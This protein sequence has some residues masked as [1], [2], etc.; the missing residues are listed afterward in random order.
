MI[1]IKSTGDIH[2][3]L[4]HQTESFG[5]QPT[6]QEGNEAITILRDWLEENASELISRKNIAEFNGTMMQWFHWYS[7]GDGNHW[8]S[9]VKQAPQLARSGISAVWL[10]PA[11]KGMGGNQE[12]GYAAYDLYD[13]GEFN[14]QGSIRTKYGTKED[15]VQAI[16]ACKNFGIN[17]YADV[18]FNHKIGG[19][20]EEDFDA[21][22][23]DIANRHHALGPARTIRSWTSFTFPGRQGKYSSMQW[24]WWHFDS[25]DY[26]ALEPGLHAVWQVKDKPLENNVNLE[27][28]NYD[29]LMGC[30]LDVAHPE[31]IQELKS[32]GEWNLDHLGVNGFRL[33]AIK[34]INSNF[35]VDWIN[36]IE[37]YAQRDVFVVGEYWS[38]DLGTLSW[39]ATQTGGQMSLFD[40][41]LHFNF[42]RASKAGGHFDMRTILDG[43]LMK[44]M[45]LLAVTLV[46][47][48]DTQPL[49]ALESVVESW[50]K[51]LAYA[52][53]LLRAE[54]YPCIFYPDYYGAT[55]SDFG[56]DGNEHKIVLESHRNILDHLLLARKFFAYGE[57]RDYFDNPNVIGWTRSGSQN[58]QRTMAVL[59]SDGP[60][61]TKWMETGR[62]H[63]SYRDLTGHCSNLVTT[64][65][66][67]WGEFACAGGSVS[68]WVEASYLPAAFG[69]V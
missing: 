9:L 20:H 10:P 42:H 4:K 52:I 25:V 17:V 36:H 12:V 41:P 39:Y 33:D 66:D 15:Y 60:Q 38:Y 23:V 26:N 46:E 2:E 50:F 69:K 59:L 1:D 54:G 61:G 5:S 57:Q 35:F 67:G 11:Y 7:N 29:F 32:W 65:A 45:P 13:L 14:Q 30:D 31:V 44:E 49:Q 51:P 47:N 53:I 21:I 34:H 43:T 16:Q 6:Q 48:H 24:H 28:G 22:P 64:N 58:H 37:H 56:P 40:A 8:R 3:Q 55:Y 68:V 62:P 18:V 27:R 19:D 63:A